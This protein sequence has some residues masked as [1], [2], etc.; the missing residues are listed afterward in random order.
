VIVAMIRRRWRV[1]AIIVVVVPMVVMVVRLD[2][3]LDRL[4]DGS[5][6]PIKGQNCAGQKNSDYGLGSSHQWFL[7]WSCLR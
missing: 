1:V 4:N 5:T 2:D 3:G 6:A 7:V